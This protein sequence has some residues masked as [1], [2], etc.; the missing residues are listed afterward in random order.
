M[1]ESVHSEQ[2]AKPAA[3]RGNREQRPFANAEQPPSGTLLVNAHQ[4]EAQRVHNYRPRGIIIFQSY[5]PF[6]GVGLKKLLVCLLLVILTFSACAVKESNAVETVNDD[7]SVT[8]EPSCYMVAEPPTGAMLAAVS[9]EGR[10][11][12]FCH[13]D[14]EVYEEIFPAQTADEAFTHIAGRTAAQL[15]PIKLSSAPREEYRFA[16][17]AA[18]ENGLL[19]CSAAAILDG[20]YC[21]SVCI[22]CRAEKEAAYQDVF[23]A[24][25]SGLELTEI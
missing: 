2:T 4:R 14:Y 19:A 17:T 15:R 3:E 25:L 24:L 8:A 9:E 12:L 13:D 16:W 20:T 1:P 7:L 18:G 5:H 23:S 11:A 22:C 6:G 10:C 21:Y